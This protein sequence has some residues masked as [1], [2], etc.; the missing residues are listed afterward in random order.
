MAAEVN[1]EWDA[2]AQ[3]ADEQQIPIRVICADLDAQFLDACLECFF[4]DQYFG[5]N[6]IVM[7]ALIFPSFIVKV[8]R[9]RSLALQLRG[10]SHP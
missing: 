8:I 2:T 9:C 5:K 3:D 7:L 1:K 6:V 10:T 4:V